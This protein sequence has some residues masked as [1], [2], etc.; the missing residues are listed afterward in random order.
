M[1]SAPYKQDVKFEQTPEEEKPKR[2]VK[3][4][5]IYNL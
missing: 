3:P 5:N 4:K 1:T 2:L